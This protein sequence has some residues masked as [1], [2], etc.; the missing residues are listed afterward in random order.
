MIQPTLVIPR[1][2][3]INVTFI[4][5]DPTDHHSFMITSFAPPFAEYVMQNMDTGGEMVQMT[6][7]IPPL[8]TTTNQVALYQYMIH[9]NYN[10]THLWYACMFPMHAN[11]GMWGNITLT[12]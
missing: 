10:T 11:Q 6:P 7:L 12:A 3:I 4:N 9:L 5:M 1:G 8:N 2:S